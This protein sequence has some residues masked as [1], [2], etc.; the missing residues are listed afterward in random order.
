MRLFHTILIAIPL[1]FSSSFSVYSH[2]TSTG[3][4]YDYEC[5]SD[6][7]CQKMTMEEVKQYITLNPDGSVAIE[8]WNITVP[9][10]NVR[11]SKDGN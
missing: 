9:A 10:E 3:W 6:E 2:S 11:E 7:D 5:C 4:Q 1:V 8:S